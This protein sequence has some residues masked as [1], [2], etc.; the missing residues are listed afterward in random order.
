M[1]RINYVIGDL[2][3]ASNHESLAHCVSRDLRMGK[4]IAVL[5]KNNFGCTSE[6]KE[7]SELLEKL[8]GQCAVLIQGQRFIYY[9]I[10]KEKAS[11]K[12]SYNDL[13]QSLEDMKS[14]CVE[15]NVK[16]IAMP[17]FVEKLLR[18]NT[19]NSSLFE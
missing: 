7:Q 11:Q 2:F 16:R 13:R 14:H 15:N 10:T 6:L 17:R 4:G 12:P 5:F 18:I 3:T 1:C 19:L 9:L 8:V